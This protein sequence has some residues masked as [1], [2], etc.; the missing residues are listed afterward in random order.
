MKT[1]S[2]VLLSLIV[3][4][5]LFA[6]GL[7]VPTKDNYPANFLKNRL[8]HVEVNV[9]GLVAETTVYQEFVNEWDRATDAVYSFPLPPDA[10]ATDFL[11]WHDDKVYKAVLKVREQAVNPGTGQGGIIAR[12]NEYIG[13]NGIRIYLKDIQPGT[14]QR[15]KLLYV[16][17]CDYYAGKATYHYPLDTGEFVKHPLEHLQFSVRV[18]SGSPITQF[19]SPTHENF[20]LLKQADDELHAEFIEP[21]A[22]IDTDF[23]FDFQTQRDELG[24]D[25]YS[26]A[27]DSVDGHFL[28]YVRPRNE[29]AP[30][31]T[32]PQRIIFVISTSN[33][34]FGYKLQQCVKA[35]KAALGRLEDTS[36]Y[37]NIIHYNNSVRMWKSDPVKA[38]AAN[39]QKA[40][41]FLDNLSSGWGSKMDAALDRALAQMTD[42]DFNNSIVLFSDGYSPIDPRG[43]SSKNNH[44]AGIF[45]IGIGDDL[46]RYRLEMTAGLNYGFV[47]YFDNDHNIEEGVIRVLNKITRPI[48]KDVAMEFGRADLY[49]M[50]P[51]TYPS[52]Y[53][54]SY[55]FVTGRYQNPMQSALA[56]A[57]KSVAG[58]R[59]FNFNL[60]FT[61]KTDTNKFAESMWAKEMIDALEQE[62]EIYGETPELKQQ[63]IDISLAYNIRCRYTAYIADYKNEYTGVEQDASEVV[64]QQSQ[65]VSNYPNPF[66]PGT[67]FRVYLSPDTDRMT[68][69][70]RIYNALG[71]LVAVIDISHLKAGMHSIQFNGRDF[72]GNSL[73]SGQYF[74]QLQVG[75]QLSSL[76]ITLMK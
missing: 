19:S 75:E 23:E 29:S 18:Q 30:D 16:S 47:T 36:D 28:L 2:L 9:H 46:A 70:I 62:I 34:M 65:L 52:A 45:P 24:V 50:L 73:P 4:L 17:H 76:R 11:Y 51:N 38:T 58:E 21:K 32:L 74:V 57:G 7:L 49:D 8:T 27:N 35:V 42:S 33:N 64:I 20:T 41:T 72:Y 55:F 39:I 40:G 61:S 68:K 10:R 56:M 14:I 43:I 12:V 25:F 3:A 48:M 63:L 26:A 1:L 67:T 53:A 59:F 6:D 5:P 37:F 66:N 54:G 71:Q 69:I 31:S 15:V 22:Y 60:N 44:K 13:R